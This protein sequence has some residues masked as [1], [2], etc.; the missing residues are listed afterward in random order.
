MPINIPLNLPAK[1][2]LER[3]NIKFFDE[4]MKESEK[5]HYKSILILNLMPEKEKTETQLLR[6]LGNTEFF[7]NVT[8][9]FPETHQ[10][11]TTKKDHLDEFYTTFSSIKNNSYD[12]MI[13]TGAPIEHLPFEDVSYWNELKVIMDW[14]KHHV[15]ST[16]HICWG[17]Q[18]GLYFHYGIDKYALDRKCSGVFPHEVLNVNSSLVKGFPRTFFAPHSRYTDIP[19]TELMKCADIEVL[20]ISNDA[21]AYLVVSKDK[22]FV[23]LTGHP[24]YDVTTLRDEYNRDKAKGL[25]PSLPVNYFPNN[26]ENETPVHL[27]KEHA[28]LLF[29]NWLSEFVV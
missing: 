2:I 3:E 10:V 1:D 22:R 16:L 14:S 12:G 25:H 23:F 26:D 9:I 24:E 21:G 13:I 17:A 28:N 7:I 8:F 18:A 11:K 6:L 27:W 4:Q 19:L 20:S 29:R 5:I 15:S